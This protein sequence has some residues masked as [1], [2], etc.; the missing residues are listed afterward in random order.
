MDNRKPEETSMYN[1]LRC[2]RCSCSAVGKKGSVKSQKYGKIYL[3][4]FTSAPCSMS[5]LTTRSFP[6]E[7]AAWR[8]S[9]LLMTELMGWP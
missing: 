9:T 7:Q 3:G 8:G 4:A 5:N 1:A 6:L 2:Q